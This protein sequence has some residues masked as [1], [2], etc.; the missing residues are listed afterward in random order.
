MLYI[1]SWSEGVFLH[2]LLLSAA[3]GYFT[4][5]RTGGSWRETTV[6]SSLLKSSLLSWANQ[7][8]K[9]KI[10]QSERQLVCKPFCLV[11]VVLTGYDRM[12]YFQDYIESSIFFSESDGQSHDRWLKTLNSLQSTRPNNSSSNKLYPS[13]STV[14]NSRTWRAILASTSN[15]S[16]G[17][18]IWCL[19][20]FGISV[21]V[22]NYF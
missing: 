3:W 11:L 16:S 17:M 22:Y 21:T 2:I 14:R 8:N 4:A 13:L 6:H 1:Q 7:T 18:S 5:I 15:A 9:R 20:L 19:Y 12:F 10:M